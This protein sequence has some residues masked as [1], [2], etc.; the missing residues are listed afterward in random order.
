[1][2]TYFALGLLVITS[3]WMGSLAQ[4]DISLYGGGTYNLGNTTS[5]SYYIADRNR[6]EL[7]LYRINNPDVVLTLGSPRYFQQTNDLDLREVRR[8][9][10][11]TADTYGDIELG[12]LDR[13]MYF[14]QLEAGSARAATLILVTDL[15]L[16]VKTDTDTVLTYSA[17]SDSGEPREAKVYLWQDDTVYAEGLADERGL[18]EFDLP[19]GELPEGL[20]AAAKYGDAWAFSDTYWQRWN[21]QVN[22]IYVHTDRPVYRPGQEVLFKGTAREAGNLAPLAEQDV[23][24]LVRDAD[25]NEILQ[26]NYVTDAYGSF[27]GTLF[28]ANEP[29]LGSYSIQTTL[30]GV[31]HYSNFAVEEYQKPE[32]RVTVI[33]D[34]P[35]AI[36]GDTTSVTIAAEYLFGG[37]VSGADVTYAVVKQPYF[38]FRYQSRYGFYEDFSYSSFYNSEIIERGEGVLDSEGKLVLELPLP[39]DDQDYTVRVQAGVTDEA[40]REINSSG[41][42]TAYRAGV[43][44]NVTTNR[45]AVNA[46]EDVTVTV[47]A[48]TLQGDPVSIPFELSA[49]RF[50]WLRNVGQ[51]EDAPIVTNGRTDTE[52]RATLT[53]SYETAGSYSLTATAQDAQGR[54]TD[55]SD[56]LWVSGSNW[57]WAYGGLTVEADKPEYTIGEVARFVIQSPIED[58][59]LL[60]SREGD[61]LYDYEMI[62]LEGSATTYDL[63]ITE[64]MAPNGF[65]S[66]VVIGD[67]QTYYQTAGFQV[68][69][70]DDFLTVTLTSDA[71]T[72]QPGDSGMFDV[73]VQNADGNGVQAQ[74]TLGLVDEA[75]YL[76]RPDT[77]PDIRGF[78]Y[79][80]RGNVVGTQLSNWY[81]FGQAETLA[82]RAPGAP[83]PMDAA[84]FAQA[85]RDFAEAEVRE[86][87]R[88]TILWL[89]FFETDASG[90]GQVEVTFP[91]NLTEWRLTARA[92]T[93]TDDVGQNTANVTSTLPVIARLATPQ[94]FVRGDEASLRVIG[95]NTLT[96][97]QPGELQFEASNLDTLSPGTQ[98][99]TLPAGA[100][101]TADFNIRA[102]ETGTATL[103]ATALTPAASD[104]MRVPIPV[105]PRG[106]RDSLA[107]A[108][109]GSDTW[110]FSLPTATDLNTVQGSLVITPSFGAAVAPALSYLAG[111]PYGCT[112]QTM[113]RFLP[114]VLAARAGDLAQLPDDVATNLDDFVDAG[115]ARLYDF[116]QNDGGWGFW[117]FDDSNLFISSYVVSGLLDAQAAGYEVREDV[118]ERA[119]V[120]LEQNVTNPN[121]TAA[122]GFNPVTTNDALAYAYYALAIAGR[123]ISG[124]P[125][126]VRDGDMTAYGLALS[127]LAMIRAGNTIEAEVYLDFL[128][129]D[130]TERGQVAYWESSAPKY[131]WNDD[132]VETTAYGLEALARLRPEDP[133][134]AKVVNWLLLERRGARWF[135]TKDTA[136]VIRSALT[137]ASLEEDDG[138]SQ[139]VTVEVNGE[140][141]SQVEL[142]QTSQM[143]DVSGL[144][145]GVNSLNINLSGTRRAYLSANID[146]TAEGDLQAQDDGIAIA[147]QYHKL[148]PSTD[149]AGQLVYE[150]ENVANV[151]VGDYV[152]ATVTLK[153]SDAYRYVIVNEPLP[154]G[155]RVIENDRVFRL[156]GEPLEDEFFY[157]WNYRYNGRDIRDERIDFYFTRLGESVTFTY[158]MR[159]ETPGQF[160]AL[161]SQ[162]WLMYEPSV[163]GHSAPFV[164]TVGDGSTL[165]IR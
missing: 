102:S 74:V 113:S 70:E 43:V 131:F 125:G 55:A 93:L 68:P 1:M 77:T 27:D 98:T 40:R 112:E 134:I 135:S 162:A 81:Y 101:S 130:I 30:D 64:D 37:A 151:S 72:Y 140:V 91:D 86:D 15:S 39:P 8:I 97:D 82:A 76:I 148:V 80:L 154:A 149:E 56:S 51:Q 12:T 109:R 155:L 29:P 84:V 117:Q 128:L 144:A 14:A 17:N 63:T 137:L 61:E 3:L 57:Y 34:D 25:G 6:A 19:D 47:Q 110:R 146:F 126:I 119:L 94:F 41:S 129:A 161:P 75:I 99:T 32:Y 36:Q 60:I 90:R 160:T 153:P 127:S 114:S 79:A 150:R 10:I 158:V 88:D 31:T 164:M 54:S 59:W 85:K 124:L 87:F 163:R 11:R 96:S 9:D 115:L 107:W 20:F 38:R 49:T 67:N 26:A 53:V 103:T 152:L 147:R 58:G 139:Q 145:A 78:F 13:G 105:L 159:A 108:S 4:T 95:Q 28:L 141:I 33:A 16:V 69:P 73:L 143:V 7:V 104:A 133:R 22:N 165:A 23:N 65:L 66:V 116:Q 44:L 123:D 83:A 100:R 46:G 122:R 24:V 136:A 71:E 52:G 35:V 157:G 42:L 48:E 106:V 111:Y 62:Q 18:T 50:Y 156:A 21:V 142:G 2:K 138:T 89:P 132:R 118:L 92:I 5:L 45:Y 121:D 120:Y